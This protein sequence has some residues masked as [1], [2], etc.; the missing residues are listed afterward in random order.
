LFIAVGGW[1]YRRASRQPPRWVI[2]WSVPR[3]RATFF[4]AIVIALLGV[5][6]VVGATHLGISYMDRTTFCA[7]VCHEVMAPAALP[8]ALSPHANVTCAECHIAPGVGGYL[9]AKMKG[10]SETWHQLRNDYARPLI[11]SDL[12]SVPDPGVCS[13]CHPVERPYGSVDKTFPSFAADEKNTPSPT[14]LTLRLGSPASGIHH[15]IAMNIRYFSTD[16]GR[17]VQQVVLTRPDGSKVEFAASGTPPAPGA[18]GVWRK[19]T[20]ITCHNRT[21]HEVMSFERRVD[22]AMAVGALPAADPGLKKRLM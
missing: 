4:A 10:A 14:R 5:F 15:H 19:V 17:T 13:R 2:D 9:Q 11:V 3:D 16:G 12:T 8:H 20:C 1:S 6:A 21:G 22:E 18:K 7:D